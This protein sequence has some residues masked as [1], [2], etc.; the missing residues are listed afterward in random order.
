M[1]HLLREKIY[2][3]MQGKEENEKNVTLL[4]HLQMVASFTGFVI[5]QLKQKLL[6][7]THSVYTQRHVHTR[8]NYIF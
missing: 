3:K 4:Q 5:T 7:G 6:L 8:I 2:A 1:T